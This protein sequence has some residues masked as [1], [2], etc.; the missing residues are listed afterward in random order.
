MEPT[1][2]NIFT[3]VPKDMKKINPMSQ[4]GRE[5]IAS[6]NEWLLCLGYLSK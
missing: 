5:R 2:V 1:F 3:V 6:E 4:K